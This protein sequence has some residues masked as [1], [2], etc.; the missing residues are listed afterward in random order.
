[1]KNFLVLSLGGTID[2]KAYPEGEGDYPSDATPSNSNGGFIVL[3]ELVNKRGN[4]TLSQLRICNK[5]SKDITEDERG[6]LLDKIQSTA[7]ERII[8]TMGTDTMTETAQ[9]LK[10]HLTAPPCPVIFTGAIWPLANG[11]GK[12]D[13]YQNLESAAFENPDIKNGIYIAMSGLFEEPKNI[14]KDFEQKKFVLVST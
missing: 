13:G 3:E 11:A 7:A 10:A 9:W 6:T 12:S 8:V 1:M 5:D 14:Y 4:I 2:A